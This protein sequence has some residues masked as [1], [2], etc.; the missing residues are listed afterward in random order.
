MCLNTSYYLRIVLNH[1]LATPDPPPVSFRLLTEYR[2][3]MIR[4][5]NRT[6]P[7]ILMKLGVQRTLITV[8]DLVL[9]NRNSFLS[10]TETKKKV[11]RIH[12]HFRKYFSDEKLSDLY[13]CKRIRDR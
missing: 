12:L 6:T 4:G 9:K 11:N 2:G 5:K 3:N 8:R 1:I 7:T 10:L 13:N